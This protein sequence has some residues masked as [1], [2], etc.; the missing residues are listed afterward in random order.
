MPGIPN[1]MGSGKCVI[2]THM[3]SRDTVQVDKGIQVRARSFY[4]AA[5]KTPTKVLAAVYKPLHIRR[6][7]YRCKHL[8]QCLVNRC[9]GLCFSSACVSSSF[10]RYK[11]AG[12]WVYGSGKVYKGVLSNGWHVAIK[13]NVKD[14]Q[15]ETFLREVTNLSHVRHPNLLILRGYC[16]KE[17]E[18]FL[19][20]ELCGNDTSIL[21]LKGSKPLLRQSENEIGAKIGSLATTP[22]YE[23]S[24]IDSEYIKGS[25]QKVSCSISKES[26]A[27]LS[28]YITNFAT[29]EARSHHEF[30]MPFA[31]FIRT[32]KSVAV[33]SAAYF[34]LESYIEYVIMRLI[35][36]NFCTSPT[37]A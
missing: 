31:L 19:V 2:G 36:S 37:E 5:V 13:H 28:K 7:C 4:A 12:Q 35:I 32:S 11:S 15:A 17:I 21:F 16:E 34:G 18:C 27:F 3:T 22:K 23:P 10:N 29:E 25:L 6:I 8:P 24:R 26:I 9:R 14:G 33:L 30:Q 20:Y 1:C